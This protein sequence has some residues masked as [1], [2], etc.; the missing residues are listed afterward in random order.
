MV[1]VP[2]IGV[3]LAY[4]VQ[5]G[6]GAL[7]APLEGVVVHEL[8]GFGI[9]AVALDLGPER[10]HHLGVTEV[11]TF[12]YVDVA[13][14]QFQRRVRLYAGDRRN[15]GLDHEGRHQFDDAAD[16]YRDQGQDAQ[17]HGLT[18]DSTAVPVF[19]LTGF[20]DGG[21][22]RGAGRF[23]FDEGTVFARHEKVINHHAEAYQVQYAPDAAQYVQRYE[24]NDG[25]E[26]I[27]IFQKPFLRKLHPHGALRPARPV[28]RHSVEDDTQCADPEV[29]VG[30]FLRV[31]VGVVNARNQPVQ[32]T[33][34]QETV[35]AKRSHVNVCNDP[36]TKMRD[37]VHVLKRKH[38]SLEGGHTVG[39]KRHDHEFQHHVFPHFVPGP[40]QRK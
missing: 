9:L 19:V 12:P 2:G 35:P 11:A 7:A 21:N 32:D 13:A 26:E 24:L 6:S 37:R 1:I 5:V 20:P 28:H 27:G 8:P 23:G 22:R 16:S 14:L 4:A 34:G 3:L 17:Q 30:Q 33:E 36:I 25:F 29:E 40:A 31:Q 10:P 39:R 15:V 18:L 38:G